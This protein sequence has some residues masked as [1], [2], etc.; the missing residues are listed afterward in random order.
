M[1]E[2]PSP[3]GPGYAEKTT[4]LTYAGNVQTGISVRGVPCR[5]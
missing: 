5:I 2:A 4:S 3:D 1:V